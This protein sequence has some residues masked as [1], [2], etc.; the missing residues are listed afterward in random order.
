MLGAHEEESYL[1]GHQFV[2]QHIV[3]TLHTL[4]HNNRICVCV[5]V[6]WSSDRLPAH[7]QHVAHS[8]PQLYNVCLCMHVCTSLTLSVLANRSSVSTPPAC[9]MLCAASTEYVCMYMLL[10]LSVLVVKSSAS[11]PPACRMLCAATTEYVCMYVSLSLSVLVIRVS[12]STL[13]ARCTL[14]P[15]I[16]KY[17]CVHVCW[18]SECLSAHFQQAVCSVPQQQSNTSLCVYLCL[19]A[20]VFAYACVYLCLC[21]REHMSAFAGNPYTHI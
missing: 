11:T 16:I 21:A 8:A 2:C 19:C 12:A 7:C 5:C 13:P 15:K 10:T 1:V 20:R 18:S 14:C 6:C 9:C 3:S 4:C 17:V